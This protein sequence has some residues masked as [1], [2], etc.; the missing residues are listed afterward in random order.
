[1]PG[2]KPSVKIG[3]CI[4]TWRTVA[5]TH[6][7]QRVTPL[8]KMARRTEAQNVF[9]LAR[10]ALLILMRPEK[11]ILAIVHGREWFHSNRQS[12]VI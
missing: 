3:W 7:G 6:M 1:M 5:L 8:Y 9:I 2:I 12:H 4:L 11:V 10:L